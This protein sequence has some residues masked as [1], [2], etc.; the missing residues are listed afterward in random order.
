[1]SSRRASQIVSIGLGVF[2]S[3]S[4]EHCKSQCDK[5]GMI[6]CS[7]TALNGN[8]AIVIDRASP[9]SPPPIYAR[10]GSSITVTVLN[11]SPFEQLSMDFSSAKAV[12]PTDSFQAFMSGQSGTLQKLSIVD[13]SQGR[14]GEGAGPEDT[15]K[16]ISKEQSN[17][18]SDFNLGTFF[19]VLAQLITTSIPTSACADAFAYAH[20]DSH[21][22]PAPL[23]N[24]WYNLEDWKEAVQKQIGSDGIGHL[25]TVADVTT[26]LQKLDS[27]VGDVSKAIA[28]LSTSEQAALKP[29]LDVVT[30]NQSTLKARTDLVAWVSQL[31]K[32]AT[33]SFT[34]KDV[35]PGGSEW[36]QA[37]WNLDATNTAAPLA[38]RVATAPYKA[39]QAGDVILSPSPKQPVTSLT[40]QYQSA[41]RLE[42]STGLMVP[43]LPF[44]SYA[45]AA[46]ASNATISGNVV[47]DSK[48]YT[49]VPLAFVN[50]SLWQGITQKQPVAAFAS[51]G[52]GYNPVT[53]GVEF[54]VGGTFSWKSLQIGALADIGRDLQLAGG[55]YVGE[56]FPA[57]NPPK[58]PTTTVWRV[59]PAI[60]LSVRIPI[61]GAG[62]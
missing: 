4:G 60:S 11:S 7:Y 21:T 5:P 23:P 40:V 31:S 48:T 45:L 2:A 10:H 55:F 3:L 25:V 28:A 38:K 51:I 19:P 53:S 58:P 14:A 54:G 34:L 16:N 50:L 6:T 44:H 17:I 9:A 26:K 22:D 8:C 46:I 52:T 62:K 13:L 39:A 41:P 18:Y 57:S 29:L 24:P 36:I 61:T 12:V 59:K 15:L 37:S 47:Q 20:R 30:Q 27:E 42:F 35:S 33:Q 56:T 1:M 43:V 32:N 49:V